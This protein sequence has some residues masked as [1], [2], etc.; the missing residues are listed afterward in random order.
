M[1]SIKNGQLGLMQSQQ[2]MLISMKEPSWE[3]LA[4]TFDAVPLL[5]P[6]EH[7]IEI[8]LIR[9]YH[10]DIYKQIKFLYSLLSTL[11]L[12][13]DCFTLKNRLLAT[14]HASHTDSQTAAFPNAQIWIA[15]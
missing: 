6:M 3:I 11:L 4:T 1:E 13:T 7:L 12:K 14:I 10:L 5:L 8:N 15:N 2:Y 9:L